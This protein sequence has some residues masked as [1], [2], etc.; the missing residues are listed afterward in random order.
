MDTPHDPRVLDV[1]GLGSVVLRPVPPQVERRFQRDAV[2]PSGQFDVNKLQRL[3]FQYAVA[4][5][6]FT[7]AEVKLIFEK[8][9]PAVELVLARVDRISRTPRVHVDAGLPHLHRQALR[10]VAVA[11]RALRRRGDCRPGPR[12]RASRGR[13]V[14][15]RGS[16]R[17][18]SAAH[19]SS[20]DDPGLGDEPSKYRPSL[21][22]GAMA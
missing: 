2:L 22:Q 15:V 19:S 21:P 14:R 17:S 10:M 5:P 16:R 20:S 4:D 9:G 12:A 18:S 3:R 13:P 8:Y 11:N 6:G 7:A 1:P